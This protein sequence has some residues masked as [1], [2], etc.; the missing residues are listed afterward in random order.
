MLT[1]KQTWDTMAEAYDTKPEDRTAWQAGHASEG[2]CVVAAWM[3]LEFMIDVE[4]RDE[5][6][7]LANAEV[8]GREGNPDWPY[9]APTNCLEGDAIR[10]KFCR[11]QAAKL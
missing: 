4:T 3:C 7:H 8:E 9:M 1:L 5:I 2:I 11:K 10:T 6:E